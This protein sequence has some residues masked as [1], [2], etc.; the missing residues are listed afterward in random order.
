MSVLEF[1][2]VLAGDFPPLLAYCTLTMG[3]PIYRGGIPY[4]A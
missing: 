4:K 3:L 1:P 2:G